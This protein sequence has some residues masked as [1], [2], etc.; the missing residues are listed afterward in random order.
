MHRYR[1]ETNEATAGCGSAV[2]R[3]GDGR[4]S[5]LFLQ[6]PISSFFD[7][8]G[9]ALIGRGHRVHRIN[10]H[11]G[12]QLFW[13][14][15]ASHFR[16]R[17]GDWRGFVGRALDEHAV[18][19]LVLHGD[20]RPYHIVAAEEARARGI[21]VIVTD[22]GY[23]RPDWITLEYDGMTTYSR[24]PR[25]A[26]TIRALA[27]TSP[28]PALGPRFQT[29]FWLIAALDILYNLGLVF[30]RPFY[31]HYR[32][33]S[34]YHPF[35]EYA[36]WI[37]SRPK[38]LL[39][40]RAT[41]AAKHRLQARP[42]SYFLVPLQISTD[43]Q[44]RAHSRFGDVREAVREIIASFAASG[45]GRQLVFVTHPLDNG[46]IGWRRLVARLAREYGAEGRVFALTGG[47]PIDLLRHAAGIVTIN[48]T[49]GVTALHHGVPLK[50]LGNAV[51]DIAGLTCQAPLDAFWIDPAPPDRA[52]TAGFLRAL[53]ATTQVKG[54]YYQRESQDCA[55]AGFIERLERGLYP[56][57]PLAASEFARR[58]PRPA[59]R[60][61]IVSGVAGAIGLALARACAAPGVR[62]CLLGNDATLDRAAEDCRH[63][64][65]LVERLSRAD[66]LLAIDRATPS[67][68]LVVAA[69]A[70]EA[71]HMRE[72]GAPDTLAAMAQVASLAAPMRR[73]GRGRIVLVGNLAG[74]TAP[75]FLAYGAALRRRLRA[76]GVA[77]T[78]VVPSRLATRAA[79]RLDAPSI[80]AVGADR[81][82]ERVLQRRGR[83]RRVIAV[84]GPATVAS[85][86][87][88]LIVARVREAARSLPLGGA[89]AIR[90]PADEAPLPGEAGPGD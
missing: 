34:I 48:S 76:D 4:R 44:I 87:L 82:A 25:D 62:L 83:S 81:L 33:H 11:F 1:D 41:R 79:E 42:G 23:V 86:T 53:V 73:R 52:L 47:T 71:P 70:A 35:A 39:R 13:R 50:V 32:Y 18:T 45:S 66:D 16:G 59:T 78:L 5:F 20:R 15:P 90:E 55:I 7:R 57:P 19:D 43:F 17:F 26:A 37:W 27:A 85:Q 84:P 61:V 56:L 6:G 69:G 46:L 22:L 80:A 2:G 38:S 64:G 77:L 24:F 89:V 9:R 14:L 67:D 30:G 72:S 58:P 68:L 8:L 65:A 60:T 36:G 63:R 10:L 51:F 31:R 49:V 54:G 28:E 21:A 74:H 29:P 12:D 88:R 3:T 75:A 40:A